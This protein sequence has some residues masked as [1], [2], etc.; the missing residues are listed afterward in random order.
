MTKNG[1]HWFQSR[2]AAKASQVIINIL[3]EQQKKMVLCKNKL[4]VIR[5]K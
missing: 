5:L 2:L 4:L 1:Y 3:Y